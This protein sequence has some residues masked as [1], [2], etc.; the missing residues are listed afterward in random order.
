[1]IAK[2]F[3]VAGAKVYIVSRK[4]DELHKMAENLRSLGE[5]YALPAD[6]GNIEN[7]DKL[8]EDFSRREDSLNILINNAGTSW[9]APFADYPVEGWDKIQDLN[10]KTPFFMIQRFLKSLK[11][12]ATIEDPSRVINISS[13]NGITNSHVPNYSYLASKAGLIH[14][15]RNLACDLAA[16]YINVNSIAP[17]YVFTDMMSYADN[18]R[19]SIIAKIP[20]GRAGSEADMAAAA[21][22]LSSRASS[23]ITGITL[24]VD[25]GTTANA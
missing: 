3:V 11:K 21:I 8:V 12:E 2:G 18:N 23:W 13:I 9:G 16:D 1:M 20:R 10:L 4:H 25:G 14:L 17:G 5:C 7:I 24:P 6:L 19:D 15:N 22:F